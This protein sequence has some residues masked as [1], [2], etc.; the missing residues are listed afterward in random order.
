MA[1]GTQLRELID[2]LRAEIGAS[3]DRSNSMNSLDSHKYALRNTQQWLYENYD[4][5]FLRVSRDKD[6]AAGQRYYSY[7]ADLPYE[8]I[9]AIYTLWGARWQPV[10]HGIDPVAD[11]NTLDENF[12][13]DPVQRW[14]SD[15]P[16]QFEVWPVPASPG[17][18]RIEGK[19]KLTPMR[20]ESDPCTLDD[21]LI[22]LYAAAKL[23]ARANAGDAPVKLQEAQ[24]LLRR[25]RANQASVK[26][27]P[28]IMG[29]GEPER[30]VRPG[31]DYIP[32]R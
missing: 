17:R 5:P 24:E 9:R 19:L 8:N 13:T 32:G 16:G 1:R 14:A 31:I 30:V 12:R 10:A 20:E 28:I 2:M 7:P 27:T 18:L 15:T 3:L 21:L 26:D 29:G 6:L 22:V 11:Y 25:L 23:L 4:W